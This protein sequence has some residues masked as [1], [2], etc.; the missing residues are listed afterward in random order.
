MR[1]S[2]KIIILFAFI[3]LLLVF[4]IPK[5]ADNHYFGKKLYLFVGLFVFEFI[6]TTLN[7][8]HNNI[9]IDTKKTIRNSI[10]TAL[11]GVISY[12]L[13][14]DFWENRNMEI[15]TKQNLMTSIVITIGITFGYLID[16]MLK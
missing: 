16:N 9:T 5:L 4:N 14:L 1:L 15:D 10:L 8:Y 12:S 6:I 7:A 13:Y 11:V 2:V 3:F